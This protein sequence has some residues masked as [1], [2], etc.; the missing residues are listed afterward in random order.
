RSVQGDDSAAHRRQ[1]GRAGA[2]YARQL[3]GLHAR[4]FEAEVARG[5]R[6]LALGAVLYRLWRGPA[7]TVLRLL[8]QRQAERLVRAASRAAQRA[9]SRGEVRDPP[10]ERM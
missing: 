3:R 8:P 6:R 10:R 5:A 2:A 1:L 9:P 7:E 4:R